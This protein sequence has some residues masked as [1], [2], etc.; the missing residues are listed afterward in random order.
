MH[1][2]Q[3]EIKGQNKYLFFLF[4]LENYI[5]SKTIQIICGFKMYIALALAVMLFVYL[6]G[7]QTR[8]LTRGPGYRSLDKDWFLL[9]QVF[10]VQEC[11]I[12]HAKKA[13]H[14][15]WSAEEKCVVF[16]SL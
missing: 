2:V 15:H 8:L 14:S 4:L 6:N 3:T 12:F 16:P 13:I 7:C 9:M 1:N 5:K 11:P 10:K